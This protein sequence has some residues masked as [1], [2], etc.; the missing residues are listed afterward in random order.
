MKQECEVG[1]SPSACVHSTHV[2]RTTHKNIADN[3]ALEIEFILSLFYDA[4]IQTLESEFA[5]NRRKTVSA[6][7]P[8]GRVD[9]EY[10]WDAIQRKPSFV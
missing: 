5:C 1:T 8:Q 7:C 3:V 4:Q 9:L 6:T 10:Y 2:T